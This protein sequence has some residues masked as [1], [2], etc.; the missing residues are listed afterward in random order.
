MTDPYVYDGTTTLK[1]RFDIRD[2]DSLTTVERLLTAVRSME[3]KTNPGIIQR[4][5][6]DLPQLQLIHR[7]L[8]QDVYDWAGDLRS[9]QISKGDS[10]FAHPQ[11]IQHYLGSVFETLDEDELKQLPLGDFSYKASYYMA[12]INAVHP[13]REGNGRA[14]RAFI[15]QM[16]NASRFSIDWSLISQDEMIDASKESMANEPI[17]LRQFL[18]RATQSSRLDELPTL[19]GTSDNSNSSPLLDDYVRHLNNNHSIEEIKNKFPSFSRV[20]NLL[21]R[22]HHVAESIPDSQKR[23][24]FLQVVHQRVSHAVSHGKPIFV[25]HDPQQESRPVHAP[26]TSYSE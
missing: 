6:N 8:F 7:H 3:L 4:Q 5:H 11:R 15:D 19:H 12:E 23:S 26:Q 21:E 22:F 9:V 25:N 14:N 2:S 24:V 1:N 10:L 16:A 20:T 18:L 13:F 17:K